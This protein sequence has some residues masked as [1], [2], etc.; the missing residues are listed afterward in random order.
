M[1]KSPKD[2]FGIAKY[3]V[4]GIIG[5][6]VGIGIGIGYFS[7]FPT[8][9]ED[10]TM[11]H[12][13]SLDYTSQKLQ[14]REES[15]EDGTNHINL[16][17]CLAYSNSSFF[18]AEV[19]LKSV[20]HQLPPSTENFVGGLH[21][22]LVVNTEAYSHFLTLIHENDLNSSTWVIPV[23]IRLWHVTKSA[24]NIMFSIVDKNINNYST[25]HSV[26][27][28]YRLFIPWIVKGIGEE[29]YIYLDTDVWLVDNIAVLWGSRNEQVWIW[30]NILV[31]IHAY[32]RESAEA[33]MCLLGPYSPHVSFRPLYI[34]KLRLGPYVIVPRNLWSTIWQVM[35]QWGEQR[36]SG[37][38]MFNAG[39]MRRQLWTSLRNAIC[40]QEKTVSRIKAALPEFDEQSSTDFFKNMSD[41]VR[42]NHVPGTYNLST[43]DR[44]WF[45]FNG[46]QSIL[47]RV[48]TTQPSLC[49]T[50]PRALGSTSLADGAWIPGHLQS[51]PGIS[52]LHNNGQGSSEQQPYWMSKRYIN[53]VVPTNGHVWRGVF[54]YVDMSWKSLVWGGRALAHVAHG[55]RL[56]PGDNVPTSGYPVEIHEHTVHEPIL[57]QLKRITNRV[58]SESCA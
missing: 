36:C 44:D 30:L 23:T 7:L 22:H 3:L 49:G 9:C 35:F 55:G 56:G 6:G 53:P 50:L 31:Y 4:A 20:L 52:L 37:V 19:L 38:M 14:S 1:W 24:S 15:V 26:A 42:R 12:D 27:Q 8:P 10:Y 51:L 48:C 45:M 58:A 47:R 39:I 13:E 16:V 18:E 41:L 5:V 25:L 57:Q 17:I 2:N 29:E 46:D 21:I 54:V 11:F 43:A 33:L 32:A 34:C 40:A 28:W